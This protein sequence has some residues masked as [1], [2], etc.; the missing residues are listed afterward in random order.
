M[1]VR[2]WHAQEFSLS[3]SGRAVL[4]D[5][6]TVIVRVHAS[7]FGICAIQG[8]QNVE[9]G[10]DRQASIIAYNSKSLLSVDDSSTATTA[11]PATMG[12]D[13]DAGQGENSHGETCADGSAGNK[14]QP[15]GAW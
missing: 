11:T 3:L 8:Q 4:Q 5:I 10:T 12:V 9:S 2:I 6:I 13:V 7:D 15:P 1:E 14:P